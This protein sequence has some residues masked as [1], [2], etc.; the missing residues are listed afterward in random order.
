[1]ISKIL[2]SHALHNFVMWNANTTGVSHELCKIQ[3]CISK[4]IVCAWEKWSLH[5]PNIQ[6]IFSTNP[7]IV[8]APHTWVQALI[9]IH[10]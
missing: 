2:N 10:L 7:L 8:K 9:D 5:W 4:G 1:M 6:D 3:T